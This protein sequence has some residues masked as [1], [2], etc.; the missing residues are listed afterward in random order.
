MAL[1]QFKANHSRGLGVTSTG[2]SNSDAN[3]GGGNGNG[4]GDDGGDEYGDV[5]SSHSPAVLNA[6]RRH[7]HHLLCERFVPDGHGSRAGLAMNGT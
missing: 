5:S 6:M 4:D 1:V 3:S 7:R 2:T